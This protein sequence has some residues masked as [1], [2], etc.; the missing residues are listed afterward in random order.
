MENKKI[1]SFAFGVV[2]IILGWTLVKHFDFEDFSFQKP[3]LDAL[4][5][6]V[7]VFSIYALIKNKKNR[8]EK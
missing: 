6:I 5:L 1:P 3:L 7:F 4:Y 8:A 2:A